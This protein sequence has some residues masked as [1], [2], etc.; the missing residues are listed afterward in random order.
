MQRTTVGAGGEFSPLTG[1]LRWAGPFWSIL[2]LK[3][4]HC[5]RGAGELCGGRPSTMMGALLVFNAD[6]DINKN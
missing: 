6:G 3:N 2:P 1:T 4:R 5:P